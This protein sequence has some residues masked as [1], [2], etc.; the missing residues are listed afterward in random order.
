MEIPFVGGHYLGRSSNVNAQ[1]CQNL[2]PVVDKQG[3]KALSLVGTPGLKFFSQYID[4]TEHKLSGK[5]KLSGSVTGVRGKMDTVGGRYPLETTHS[6]DVDLTEAEESTAAVAAAAKECRGL[7]IMGAYLYAVIGIDVFRVSPDGKMTLMK[8]GLNTYQ[9]PVWMEDNGTQLMIVDGTY[10]Y[11]LTGTTLSQITDTDFPT[12]SSLTYQDGYFIV[13]KKDT[14]RFYISDSYNGTAWDALDYA[15]AEAYPDNLQV[16]ISAHREL[17]L[18]GKESFEVWYNS[19]DATFPFERTP[20]AVNRL[21]CIA[22]HSAAQHRGTV[23][24]LDN[25]RQVQASN[26]YQAEKISTEQIDFQISELT[27]VTDAISY[28]YSQEGHTFYVL[29]FPSCNK[30]FSYDFVTGVWHTRASGP[31]DLRHPANCY[32]YF[33]GMHIVGDYGSGKLYKYDLSTYDDDGVELR[34][35]R[36]AHAVRADRKVVFHSSLEV[37]FEGGMGLAVDHPDIDSGDDPQ[38][39]LQWSDDGGHTW[40]NEHWT[41]IGRIG[42]YKTRAIWRRLGSSRDR[43]YKVT[44]SDPVKVVILGAYLEANSG[45]A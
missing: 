20:G 19:G 25:F 32:A 38:A 41:D 7:H 15:T 10:G 33:E 36:A 23:V 43:V 39:M 44:V 37:E 28:I 14:G 22:P 34:R 27:A 40:S 2:Y 12:P 30:T 11:I 6:T 31:F 4:T 35:V 3:G 45:A 16:A 21:G 9:G 8:G 42:K 5:I 24:W 13:S 1:V 17:W 18:L 26:G 29:T